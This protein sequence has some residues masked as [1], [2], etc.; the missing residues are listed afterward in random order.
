MSDVILAPS[1]LPPDDH[2]ERISLFASPM[3]PTCF[4]LLAFPLTLGHLALISDQLYREA[5][6]LVELLAM[7]FD[8]SSFISLFLL[9]SSF[10]AKSKSNCSEVPW[11]NYRFDS[12]LGR[13]CN[14]H[15]KHKFA[16][17]LAHIWQ[18]R[19]PI[20]RQLAVPLETFAPVQVNSQNLSRQKQYNL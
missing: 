16:R 1:P 9:I 14:G 6:Q 5:P 19:H 8:S 4:D 2:R 15:S 7:L 18:A 12:S 13:L 11:I 20:T 10:N 3:T 17:Y